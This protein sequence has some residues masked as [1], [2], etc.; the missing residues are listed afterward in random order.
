MQAE[1]YTIS[2]KTRSVDQYIIRSLELVL[3]GV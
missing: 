3:S 2:Q 1:T